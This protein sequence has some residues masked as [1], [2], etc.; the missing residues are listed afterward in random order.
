MAPIRMRRWGRSRVP[1]GLRRA[2]Y[3]SMLYLTH[4]LAKH[5]SWEG[6]EA[7]TTPKLT[8]NLLSAA[9]TS[10]LLLQK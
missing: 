9:P 8:Q 3:V 2:S 6:A 10:G 4:R 1:A 5:S 7:L